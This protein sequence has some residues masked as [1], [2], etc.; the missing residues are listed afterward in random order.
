M[1]IVIA[2]V[3]IPLLSRERRRIGNNYRQ[4]KTKQNKTKQK[5]QTYQF[6]EPRYTTCAWENANSGLRE[7]EHRLLSHETNIASQCCFQTPTKA[8]SVDRSDGRHWEGGKGVC[9]VEAQLQVTRNV[10]L[11]MG[12]RVLLVLVLVLVLK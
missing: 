9:R 11:S 7:A 6:A 12:Q 3:Y 5:T 1:N 4:N 10:I 2:I 8:W